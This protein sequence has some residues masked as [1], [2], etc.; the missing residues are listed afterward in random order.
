MQ[1]S[2]APPPFS[3]T[4]PSTLELSTHASTAPVMPKTQGGV[5]D[6]AELL[7]VPVLV[8]AVALVAAPPPVAPPPA[9]IE[10]QGSGLMPGAFAPPVES[11]GGSALRVATVPPHAGISADNS[12][13]IV[14]LRMEWS[15]TAAPGAAC[16]SNGSSSA[17]RAPAFVVSAYWI[18]GEVLG[19]PTKSTSPPPA[20]DQ[21][22]RCGQSLV[23]TPTCQLHVGKKSWRERVVVSPE[24]VVMT[25]NV[26]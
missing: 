3:H 17:R 2:T 11:G 12:K 18:G 4:H 16:K 15:S 5:P 26:P 21:R 10:S 19:M 9:P 24:V 25:L 22:M 6:H 14:V 1:S 20:A 23:V 8:V 13:A 7:P